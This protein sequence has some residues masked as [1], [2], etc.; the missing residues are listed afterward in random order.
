VTADILRACIILGFVS[1]AA[2]PGQAKS[3]R[4]L[5]TADKVQNIRDNI[6]R[7]DW[8][9]A[10]QKNAVAAA[11]KLVEMPYDELAKYAPDP[12][13]PRAVYVHETGCPNC[14]LAMRKYG[15][16]S[17]I[18][19]EDMPYKVKC[20]NCG[21]VYPSNDYQAFIDSGFQDRSLLTG[22][23]PDDGWGW[24]SPKDPKHKYWF[25]AWYNHWMTQRRLLPSIDK[26]ANAYL[27]TDDLRYARKCAVMLWQLAKYYPDYDYAKQSRRGIEFDHGYYGRLFYY[28]WETSTV[29][30][31]SRAYDAIF[32]ALLESCPELEQFTGQSMEEVRH[33]I[34]E[35]LLRS[36][37]DEIVRE[38]HYIG[39]NYGSHQVGLL[40]IAAVLKDTPGSPS[41]EEMVKWMLDNEEYNIYIYM[42]IYDALYNLVYRDGVPF[43]S[44][45]YNLGWVSNLTVIADLLR[46][47]GVDMSQVPRFRKLY[48]WTI[49]ILCAGRFTPAVGDS[50]NI[51]GRGRLWREGDFLSAYK[52]YR[53]PLYAKILLELNPE[54]GRDI[55]A[56]PLT[57][58]LQQA[59]AKVEAEPGYDSR[60]LA[61]Y[62]LATLQNRNREQPI[63]MSL[64]Y[65][66][67]HGHSH[68]D[69]MQLDIF[70]QNCAMTPDF[71]YPET[72]NSNDPR[73]AGF[74][75]HTISH[76]T[77]M[78]DESKQQ[79]GR[80]R[81][82][83]YDAGPI[84]QY[85]EAQND[86]VYAQCSMYRR[87]VAMVEVS[88]DRSYF[89]DIFRVRGGSQ[90]DWLVH[91]SHADIE[92]N[93]DLPTPRK[94][95]LAGPD[96]EYGYYYDDKALADVPYGSANYFTYKGSA[97]QFL[98]NVQEA[99]LKPDATATWRFISSGDRAVPLVKANEGAYLKAF[100][101]GENEQVYVC[102]GKPQQNQKGT[103]E[104]VKFLVRRRTGDDLSSTFITVF[105][106][107]AHQELIKSVTRIPTDNADLVALR[108][109]LDSG[110]IHYYFNATEPVAETDIAD[111]IRF[112]GAAYPAA[113]VG[114]LA[115]NDRGEVENAYLHN[116]TLLSRGNWK[117]ENDGPAVTTIAS[118]D[119]KENSV[120]LADPVLAER[121]AVG[122]TA[123]VN[124]GRYGGTFEVR[125]V[126][127]GDKLLFGDQEPIRSRFFIK[128]IKPSEK[129]LVTPTTISF[130]QP[131]MHLV[132]EALQPVA[133]LVS[134]GGGT[135][136]ADRDFTA[137][138]WPDADRDG[139]ARG[140]IMEYGPGDLVLI[141]SSIRYQ[142]H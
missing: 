118:C 13:I 20:P 130:G 111:G 93:L 122:S 141:P 43:E 106:P 6:Q 2:L 37:A 27:Y 120:T 126:Q 96:V 66:Q 124:C 12:R 52:A 136:L 109:E 92:S 78:V 60:H 70:A 72:A 49:Q 94:G 134:A 32:P 86:N 75:A 89:I 14:G 47:N 33:L 9:K 139:A 131:T 88:P 4:T 84:C 24:A 87:G 48:D 127:G 45:G 132:N 125:G 102:D 112:A 123:I 110:A 117:I 74:F 85:V 140:Y 42:P 50:G 65:G 83:A 119:Y 8:A 64:F 25:V 77:V 81:C 3:E 91:G 101:V 103:P 1:I 114:Y 31:C 115:L 79:N 121:E 69:K 97:F 40:Q 23:Y 29:K 39:G 99:P 59:A 57:D 63:A 90:H 104:S 58:E 138:Q 36:M 16:Y 61:G 11:A 5:F 116:A 15:N 44:P 41:S 56:P 71:G 35:Q 129:S 53:D 18:I 54:A 113:Q 34:E 30:S 17:W 21:N 68:L 137:E 98:Y 46:A 73:R 100:L 108:I 38:T 128:E 76:N 82:L 107:G 135:V 22:D 26:L 62:G 105:E 95:T 133:K 80:G 67:F 28:T 19:S 51:S 7:Y 55:A 142:R 10:V